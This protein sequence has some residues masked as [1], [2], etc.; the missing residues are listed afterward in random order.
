MKSRKDMIEKALQEL[1]GN[2]GTKAEIFSKI[3]DIFKVSL[4]NPEAPMVRTLSQ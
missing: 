2:K 1:P 4:D 3:S